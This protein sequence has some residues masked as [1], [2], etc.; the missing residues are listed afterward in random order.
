MTQNPRAFVS[1]RH[2]T[3][4]V[5]LTSRVCQQLSRS[6]FTSQIFNQATEEKL[7]KLFTLCIATNKPCLASSIPPRSSLNNSTK[8][9]RTT[10]NTETVHKLATAS[11]FASLSSGSL[12]SQKRFS[13][14]G[15]FMH[16]LFNYVL[17]PA[18]DKAFFGINIR[19]VRSLAMLLLSFLND[20]FNQPPEGEA[21][22]VRK[23]RERAK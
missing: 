12:C 2:F 17:L 16:Q 10:I 18:I 11:H 13:L 23:T 22:R 20:D 21:K 19:F 7:A 1:R 15:P 9:T 6:H 14:D 5:L 3:T 4:S 8:S